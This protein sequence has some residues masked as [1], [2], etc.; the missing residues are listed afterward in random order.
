[1]LRQEV[2]DDTQ[3]FLGG[4]HLQVFFS[5]YLCQ[6]KRVSAQTVASYRDTFRLFLMFVKETTGIEPSTL[7]MTDVDALTVVSFLESL[8][9]QRGNAIR[10]RN[11]RLSAV[12]A[13][14]RLVALRDPT[15]I[16][17]ATRVLAI[18]AKR[19]DKKIVGYLTR[20]EMDALLAAPDRSRWVGRRDH[21]L[22]LTMYN[23]GARVSEMVAL[24][25]AH[26]TFGSSTLL[27]LHGTGRK[28][29]T[30]PLWPPTG[31][32]LRAWFREIE[33][34]GTS[35]AFPNARGKPLSRDSV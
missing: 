10:S 32:V 21:A 1:M 13:F 19:E 26:V 22:L 28:E 31:R 25:R 7:R 34:R 20:E 5:D 16:G 17:I 14:F 3:Q 2:R 18:P 15:S 29:R 6:Q 11:L 4:P 33:E 8:E 23:S 12:R 35:T 9:R 24:E 27:H 30:V